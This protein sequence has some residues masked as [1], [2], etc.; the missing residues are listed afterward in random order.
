[1][2]CLHGL[3]VPL[4]S[5]VCMSHT[6]DESV[7]AHVGRVDRALAGEQQSIVQK[8]AKCAAEEG[9]YHGNLHVCQS[10]WTASAFKQEWIGAYP[11]VVVAGCPDLVAV[12][13]K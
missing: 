5:V 3:W 10:D 7:E 8:A 9:S 13:Y 2:L 1:M 6:R 11:E 12:P 4:D